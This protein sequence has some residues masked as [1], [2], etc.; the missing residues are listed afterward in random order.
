MKAAEKGWGGLG[1]TDAFGIPVYA[2]YR[3]C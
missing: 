2:G 1:I 3:G